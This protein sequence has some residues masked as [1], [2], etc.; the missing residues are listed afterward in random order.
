M[1]IDQDARTATLERLAPRTLSFNV[2]GQPCALERA[3]HSRKTGRHYTEKNTKSYQ[4]K[5]SEYAHEV[6]QQ[7]YGEKYEPI[8]AE[9]RVRAWFV[10][11]PL[12]SWPRWKLEWL[13]AYEAGDPVPA[14]SVTTKPDF[15]NLVKMV[16]ALT[17]IVWSDDSKVS[18]CE[19]DKIYG[20][21]PRATFIITPVY[22]RFETA[23]DWQ[24][25]LEGR[26]TA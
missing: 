20:T 1:M 22:P 11:K 14:V 2:P 18:S 15:D 4:A 5:L 19:I 9:I 6:M 23:K 13:K 26:R 25:W 3:R 16:D 7:N 8:A 21:Q 17:G 10:F 24:A 12:K